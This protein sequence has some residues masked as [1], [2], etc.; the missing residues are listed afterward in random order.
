MTDPIDITVGQ[1]IRRARHMKGVTQKQIA[2]EVG[3]KF[4]QIQKYETGANRVSAS[5]LVKIARVLGI[6]VPDLF[7]GVQGIRS[8]KGDGESLREGLHLR[9]LRLMEESNRHAIEI[10]SAFIAKSSSKT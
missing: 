9:H 10:L 5:R 7:E 3:C 4:Q 1:N 8:D 6:G 2:D